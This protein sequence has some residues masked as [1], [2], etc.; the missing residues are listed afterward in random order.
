MSDDLTG[1]NMGA[2]DI[3]VIGM[4]CRL[5]GSSNPEEYW[6]NLK[7]GRESFTTLSDDELREADVSESDIANPNYVKTGMFLEDMKCF[8]AGF[9]GF[10]PQDA[11]I[12]DPQ[13]RHFLECA[14]ETFEDAGYIPSE[15]EGSVGVY[16][17]SGHNA[18][19]PYNLMTNPELLKQVGFFLLRHT[20]NDKDFLA[21]RASYLFN[22]LGPSVNVQTA[23]STSL[24]GVHL[25]A[26]SLLS[27]ECDMAL[28][29]GVTINM[30]HNQGYLYKENEILSP[31]GHCR[32]FEAASGGTVF[33]SGV[34]CILL[35]RLEDALADGDNIHA[36]IKASA[37]N[38]DGSN[39]VSYLA[40]SVD[41][42]AA[43]VRET[44]ELAEI[45][46]A[47]VS[48][49]ECHGTGTAMGD[50]IEVSALTQAY[51]VDNPKK[52]YCA[53][54]SAKSNIGHLDAAAGVAGLIKVVMSLKNKQIPAT[55]HFNAPNPAIDFE[56][57]PFYVNDRLRNWSSEGKRRAGVSSLGV[58]GTNAHVILEEYESKSMLSGNTRP[59]Q[60]ML[61][62]GRSKEVVD[63]Y[64]ASNATFFENTDESLV[65][66]AYTSAVG[67]KKF[68]YRRV[69]VG[70]TNA[71]MSVVL[72]AA[73]S[74]SRADHKA[75]EEIAP[76]AFMF[77]GGGAQYINMG[78]GLYEHEAFYK[79]TLDECIQIAQDMLDFDLRSIVFPSQE[80]E[81]QA[82][83]DIITPSRTLP[84]LFVTQY[85]QALLWQSW[86]VKAE[87]FIGHSVGEYTAACLAGV[88]SFKDALSIVIKRG[89]LFDS[90]PAGGMLSVMLDQEEVK[91]YLEQ[92]LS[93]AAINSQDLCVLSGPL[94]LIDSVQEKLE[95]VEVQCRRVRISVA[96]H[97]A[98]LNPI[99]EEFSTF[100]STITYYPPKQKVVSNLTGRWLTNEEAV[101]PQY[102]VR[103][104]RGTVRFSDGLSLLLADEITPILLEVGPGNTLSSFSRQHEMINRENT[105]V[106]S[107]KHPKESLHD[108]E[109]M[110]LSLGKLWC[111][112]AQID[113]GDFYEADLKRVSI[114]TYPF[115]KQQ[116]WVA[117]GKTVEALPEGKQALE[118]WFYQPSW[119]PN[120][121]TSPE[122]FLPTVIFGS[123]SVSVVA[124]I[125]TYLSKQTDLTVTSVRPA[126]NS[127]STDDNAYQLNMSDAKK[128]ESLFSSIAK[129]ASDEGL[130]IVYAWPLSESD[131]KAFE[132]FFRFSQA[133][134]EQDISGLRLTILVN[135]SIAVN[136]G[137]NIPRPL[138]A[139][140]SGAARVLSK[141][142]LSA[143]V[144]LI[145][146]DDIE[147]NK[148]L[149]T[150]AGKALVSEIMTAPESFEASCYRSG[151]RYIE[152]FSPSLLPE[153]VSFKPSAGVYVITGGLGGL[154]LTVAEQLAANPGIKLALIS[155]REMPVKKYW[156]EQSQRNTRLGRRI[157]RLLNIAE[158]AEQLEV[159][160]ADVTNLQ[161]L[162]NVIERARA[163]LGPIKGAL[164]TAGS[165]D[166]QLIT[167]KT[168]EKCQSVL[169]PKIA[170]AQALTSALSNDEL[171]FLVFYSSVSSLTGMSGQFD[172]AAAN[173]YLDA[174]AHQSR[175]NGIPAISINWSAWQHVGMAAELASGERLMG[176]KIPHFTPYKEE[177]YYRVY[178]DSEIWWVDE[179][180]T[181]TGLALVPG[182]GYIDLAY[183]A[184]KVLLV[185]NDNELTD[186]CIELSDIF[187]SSP[188]LVHDSEQKVIDI[189][190][191]LKGSASNLVISSAESLERADEDDWLSEHV[192]GTAQIVSPKNFD[193]VDIEVIR[194]NCQ[195]EC[196]NKKGDASH[197][198]MD[199]GNRW[200]CINQI[201][202]GDDEVLVELELPEIF[203]QD[204][205]STPLHPGMLDMATGAGHILVDNYEPERDFFV[206]IS[207]GKVTV[208]GGLERQIYS[209]IKWLGDESDRSSFNI[210]IYSLTGRCL[211]DI[212]RFVVKRMNANALDEIDHAISAELDVDLTL[213][214]TPVEGQEVLNRVLNVSACPQVIISPECF[215]TVVAKVRCV[216]IAAGQHLEGVER[217]TLDADYEAPA[218]PFE[219]KMAALWSAALGIENIGVQDNFFELGGHSLLLTQLATKAKRELG[220]SLPL[221]KLFDSPT[222]RE[223]AEF[224]SVQ[225]VGDKVNQELKDYGIEPF[226]RDEIFQA[227][228]I[229]EV[230]FE[231]TLSPTQSALWFI[232]EVAEDNSAYNIPLAMRFKGDLNVPALKSAFSLLIERHEI[233][234]TTYGEHYGEMI[235]VISSIGVVDFRESQVD[236][237]QL[238][239]SLNKVAQQTFD[240]RNDP[241]IFCHVFKVTEDDHVVLLNLH[242]ISVD[243]TALLQLMKELEHGYNKFS[244]GESPQFKKPHLHYADY[245]HWLKQKSNK[246]EQKN[247][248]EIWKQRL[249]GFSGVLDLP[250]DKPRPAI[251]S[252]AGAQYLFE[253][254]AELSEKA[255][256]FSSEQSISL[257]ITLLS[258]FCILLNRYSK[259]DD[260]IVATPFANRANQE[261]LENVIGCFINTLP[262]AT[263]LS[264]CQ[265][266]EE[267]ISEVKNVMFEAYDNQDIPLN[268]IVDAV[269][270]VRDLS[271]N[272][273]FQVGFIFQEPPAG[274]EFSGLESE[275]LPVHSGGAMYD[276]H[277]WLWQKEGCL[278]GL[279][280]YNTDIFIEST[281][282]RLSEHFA[283]F[284]NVLTDN[285]K[286]DFRSL[287]ILTKNEQNLYQDM[288][289]TNFALPPSANLH[290]LISETAKSRPEDIAVVGQDGQLTYA[291]LDK[292][293]DQLASYLIEYGV[294]VGNSVGVSMARRCD[295]LVAL[296]GILKTGASYIPMDPGY[297]KERLAYMAEQADIR[298]I[299]TCESVKD[300][301]DYFKYELLSIDEHWNKISDQS[302]SHQ[303]PV[304]D[305]ENIAYV[306][307]TSGSTGLPK[308]VQVPHRSVVNFLLS[309]ANKPGFATKDRLLAITTLSFDIAVLELYLPLVVGGRT[310]IAS[311]DAVMDG[312]D[313]KDLIQEHEISVMQATPSTW[314][315]LLG[316]GWNG[317][318][319]R[320]L[321]GGE[322]F[323]VDLASSLS[324]IC[325]EVWN[326]YGPTETTVWSTCRLVNP[327]RPNIIGTP[328]ANTQCYV[329]N[330]QGQH[331]PI[332]VEGELYIGGQG[333]THGY[334][335]RPELTEKV[336]VRLSAFNN[337]LL[338]R[339]GDSVRLMASGEIEYVQRIDSQV[340]VR[341]YRIELG[342]IESVIIKHAAVAV[343]A[344]AVKEYTALD[345]RIVAYLRFEGHQHLTMTDLRRYLRDFLPDYMIPQSLVELDVMPLTPNGKI[346]RKA[347]PDPYHALAND[348]KVLEPNTPVEKALA[349]LWQ[350]AIGV[351]QISLDSYFFDAGGHSML[352]MQVI[353]KIDEIF[354]VRLK[355][356]D[357]VLNTLEQIAAM[358]PQDSET[359]SVNEISIPVITETVI[360]SESESEKHKMG[361]LKRLLGKKK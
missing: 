219:E 357:M 306:I 176:G 81:E 9:F 149:K 36:V 77:A 129:N 339:T 49:I 145:D 284:L 97:S 41:G 316:A 7:E 56:N 84:A 101:D 159:Y 305:P 78:L 249:D 29:G 226:V 58:G 263:D 43:A 188:L 187:F 107:M 203:S 123:Q 150:S 295:M 192:E 111:G 290:S 331:Q 264:G 207:Y 142:L 171:D 229:E 141:E 172:Y 283:S 191:E 51:S 59:Y 197:P 280:W 217:P 360:Q 300:D 304:V 314:R 53:L 232:H 132:H 180:R 153:A 250:L 308:G 158:L 243:H 75:P 168:L 261:D 325:T 276:I 137:E 34:G 231:C 221:S 271:Y 281:I 143:K 344:V 321:C 194:Q 135:G 5:P 315:S 125:E 166:D 212:D 8:D 50:P 277:V 205:S 275:L 14:W 309:M 336:F 122:E 206:P 57:S 124:A 301:I 199:F 12:M 352:S 288:N 274:I 361:F 246:Q 52:Q 340:K 302:F 112:G 128:L 189:S 279:I 73:K 120:F 60:L 359:S 287:S 90:L 224:A 311:D 96:A 317:G 114:P 69:C 13:H 144:R 259:Q 177:N 140:I 126:V 175:S 320:I 319:I 15:I 220:A 148:W 136:S 16:A 131:E 323:P 10:S 155:H 64:S 342:E 228:T 198:H 152:H 24:V 17:G 179:H 151:Y 4:A 222:I 332:G 348:H 169:A 173:A 174:F 32:P 255:A 22:L 146:V 70:A 204:L 147:L 47:S 347:L 237:E 214:I 185:D 195:K 19:L 106:N 63:R 238:E 351:D 267:V 270:P 127:E 272:P 285:S 139:T 211:I 236:A 76:V 258:N 252:G 110:L 54:G 42:Q 303:L 44:I 273:L 334:L 241:S 223:W 35:K 262:L 31:D 333:V 345:K 183:Q 133:L 216:D 162:T 278:S 327:E 268:M 119:Q 349:E 40:P 82:R 134:I 25:A 355:P 104:L 210:R 322:P 230:K 157:K 105:V 164:H 130:A 45:D 62:S 170:G 87:L 67:R 289:Q 181:K 167:L 85:A 118:K 28:A 312:D 265:N 61:I 121:I 254:D 318:N 343:C 138:L 163:E 26:Q 190:F 88:F 160:V 23:C 95:S 341:G 27:G 6:Q 218:S 71:E 324:G 99:L 248:I 186:K 33:G 253:Y 292:R 227:A 242:H 330:E 240:L 202:I 38:N 94:E 310:V 297:P 93:L 165:I 83:I 215:E 335:N 55:L 65:N 92:G 307:F 346:D 354:G 358:L 234:R 200:A 21:T 338:Y 353:Y 299:I 196:V 313:L 266:F 251:A 208:L 298:L 48:F 260:I 233:L 178:V 156:L 329:L 30:P 66:I 79:S 328:I 239:D 184:A 117:P 37:I 68:R 39:K 18:Y 109:F 291:E 193:N 247:K 225:T 161:Q 91:P 294:T 182:T 235:Q 115:E 74:A 293:S 244:K 72:S 282:A 116:H 154:G 356:T 256:R 257:Y 86:G 102:W 113:W 103:H 245:V 213:G 80:N 296:L 326:M 108:V 337:E 209:H 100:L 201:H 1:T 89:A 286:T 2:N 3:A 98:M 46:P 11:R 350:K 20:G 269:H